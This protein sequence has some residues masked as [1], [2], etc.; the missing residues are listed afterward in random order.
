[1]SGMPFSGHYDFIE[2]TMH[3]PITHMVPPA[4]QALKCG[5]CH[6]QESRLA[7]LPG[8]YIPGH[9]GNVWLD[10]IGWLLVALTLAGVVLHGLLRIL[11]KGRKR[12]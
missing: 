1:M 11:L 8:I 5:A 3:W 4:E 9:T 6:G 10:R 7:G 2:T 12:S